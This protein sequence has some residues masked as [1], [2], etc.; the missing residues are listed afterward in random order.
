M[1]RPFDDRFGP[2][3][4]MPSPLVAL[5]A[6][7]LYAI[8][9]VTAWPLVLV[10]AASV[11]FGSFDRPVAAGITPFAHPVGPVPMPEAS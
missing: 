10:R 11:G 5:G 9:V 6:S 2:V 8:A 3:P 7:A 1:S 4:A